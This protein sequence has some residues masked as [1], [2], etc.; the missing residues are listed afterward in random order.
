MKLPTSIKRRDWLQGGLALGLSAAT[1]WSWATSSTTAR[2]P[3]AEVAAALP[4]AYYRGSGKLTFLR[5][6]VYDARLWVQNDFNPESFEQQA[7]ALELEYARKIKG[8]L[9]AERSLVEM[10]K[11]IEVSPPQAELWLAEM[12]RVFPDVAAGDRITGLQFPGESTRFYF[13]GKLRG[14]VRDADFTRAFF[15]IWLSPRTSEPKLR[16]ALLKPHLGRP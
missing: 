4:D 15:S 12:K 14:E 3:P 1:S 6:H 7:L 8:D 2:K 16:L 13:N 9:I 11:H 10:R 5:L